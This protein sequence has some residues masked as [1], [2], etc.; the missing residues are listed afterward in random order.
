MRDEVLFRRLPC[1]RLF[2]EQG[3]RNPGS[4]RAGLAH[5]HTGPSLHLAGPFHCPAVA[6]WVLSLKAKQ[7][8]QSRVKSPMATG[9]NASDAEYHQEIQHP[10]GGRYQTSPFTMPSTRIGMPSPPADPGI[11]FKWQRRH[12]VRGRRVIPPPPP[13]APIPLRHKPVLPTTPY[14]RAKIPKPVHQLSKN[15]QPTH[16][17]RHPPRQHPRQPPKTL[18]NFI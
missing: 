16:S 18:D 13:P 15:S 6:A 3:N 8:L 17:T 4:P 7:T 14:C 9:M 2:P 12:L 10:S 11:L 1:P 5:H